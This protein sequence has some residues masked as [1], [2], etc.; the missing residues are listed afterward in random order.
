[1]K[2]KIESALIKW[3]VILTSTLI[4][5]WSI[6]KQAELITVML[7]FG[8]TWTIFVICF[9]AIGDI[10]SILLILDTVVIDE[11]IK[12]LFKKGGKEYETEVINYMIGDEEVHEV[13]IHTKEE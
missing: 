10:T 12:R 4:L 6:L 9:L 11:E 8:S 2:K 13:S 7:I 3:A 5:F 1:M